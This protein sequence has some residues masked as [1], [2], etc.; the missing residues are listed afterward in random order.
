MVDDFAQHTA[1]AGILFAAMR[2]VV[3][4]IR[5]RKRAEMVRRAELGHVVALGRDEGGARIRWEMRGLRRVGAARRRVMRAE[6]DAAR[7]AVGEGAHAMGARGLEAGDGSVRVPDA[8]G[9][10]G[11]GVGAGA[12]WVVCVGRVHVVVAVAHACA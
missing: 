1:D 4:K 3:S 5:V 11:A 8:I 2:G 10:H 7:D 12:V 9:H 6:F